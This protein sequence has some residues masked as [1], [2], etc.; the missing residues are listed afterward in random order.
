[1]VRWAGEVGGVA[2]QILVERV[3]DQGGHGGLGFGVRLWMGQ[4]ATLR[5]ARA[6]RASVLLF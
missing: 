6:L 2:G 4:M 5:K 3:E 1:M